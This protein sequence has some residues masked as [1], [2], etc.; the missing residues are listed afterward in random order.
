MF[1][2]EGKANVTTLRFFNV[3]AGW[4]QWALLRSDAHHDNPGCDQAMELR[5][6]EQA[7]E[8]GAFVVDCGD[9]F[10]A[11][12]GRWD[13]RANKSKLRPEHQTGSYLDA[14]ISTAADFYEP[15]ARNFVTFGRGNHE[16]TVKKNHETDL[17]ERLVATLNDRA[18]THI[19]ASG[20]T[21]WVRLLT[22]G[23][24]GRPTGSSVIWFT[25]GYGGGGPVTQD[26]IQAQR[27][28]GYIEGADI[29][30]SGHTHD[31]WATDTIKLRINAMGNVERRPLSQIKL[32]TYVDLYG[33]GKEGWQHTTGKVPKPL[34]AYW[35]RFFARREH[36]KPAWVDFEITRAK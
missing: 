14:L 23:N 4:D 7:K 34:G 31:S 32:P 6:L 20:Y 29:M 26:M 12:Q 27:Q 30:L 3:A 5:H 9:L 24:A 21:G 33:D 19:H 8:R 18:G 13:K 1:E 15:F 10:C 28:R 25:H 22:T 16:W 35:V 2:L 17:T 36:T 11:M